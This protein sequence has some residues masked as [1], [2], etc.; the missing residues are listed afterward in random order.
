MRQF[1]PSFKIFCVRWTVRFFRLAIFGSAIVGMTLLAGCISTAAPPLP[2]LPAASGPAPSFAAV[3]L[4]LARLPTRCQR[5]F[6]AT[7]KWRDHQI[8]MIGRVNLTGASN[9]QITALDE[10]GQLL[11]LVRQQPAHAVTVRAAAGFPRRFAVAIAQDIVIALLPP[12]QPL[13]HSALGT[14]D[15][16]HSVRLSYTDRLGNTHHCM[17]VGRQGH[18]RRAD[19]ALPDHRRLQVLYTRY[20]AA[21]WPGT[22]SLRE[23]DNGWLLM[24]NFTGSYK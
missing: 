24:L 2:T 11:F 15:H 14:S 16:L 22:L 20:N 17:F 19:I 10:F 12:Q 4:A 6:F 3:A 8:S 5:S 9:F 18:L 7:L 1:K 21:G 13:A 23:P